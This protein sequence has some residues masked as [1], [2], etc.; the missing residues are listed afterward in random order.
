LRVC[1]CQGGVLVAHKNLR[2]GDYNDRSEVWH[3]DPLALTQLLLTYDLLRAY[4]GDAPMPYAPPVAAL[5]R[6]N[7][8]PQAT[9]IETVTGR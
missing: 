6:L 8:V 1:Q 4:S 2:F 3:S 7:A 9:P 5:S